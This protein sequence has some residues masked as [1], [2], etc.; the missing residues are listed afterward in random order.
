MD[1]SRS[2]T[3][4]QRTKTEIVSG[5]TK[6]SFK[7]WDKNG[8]KLMSWKPKDKY[9]KENRASSINATENPST[10]KTNKHPLQVTRPHPQ[11]KE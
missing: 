4:S 3:F 8:K 9:K 1:S 5:D 10:I 6:K 2:P 7:Q 11:L